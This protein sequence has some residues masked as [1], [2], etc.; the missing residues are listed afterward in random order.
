[1]VES[2][3]EDFK[4][5]VL[6]LRRI[7]SLAGHASV[8]SNTSSLSISELGRA[9]DLGERLIGTHYWNPPILMPLVEVILGESTDR[10]LSSAVVQF[11][12]DSGKEPVLVPDIPGFVWNR[13][14]FALLREAARLVHERQVSPETIDVIMRKGL[15]RRWSLLG[16][17]EAM[18]L[19]GRDT[20]IAVARQLFPQIAA[21]DVE[22]EM[23]LTY[24][25]HGYDTDELL[26]RRDLG[27]GVLLRQDAGAQRRRSPS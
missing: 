14:L 1:M 25:S 15:G 18:A 19:G 2:V 9:S 20:F 10:L 5:K 16:P 11:L 7:A 6:M 3:A 27:L 12:R 4:V 22:A 17:F 8:T 23:L 24:E 26:R 21:A 13:L